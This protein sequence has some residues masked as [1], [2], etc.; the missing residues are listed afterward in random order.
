M[1]EY[2][3][4]QLSILGVCGEFSLLLSLSSCSFDLDLLQIVSAPTGTITKNQSI[5]LQTAT[6]GNSLSTQSPVKCTEVFN[7]HLSAAVGGNAKPNQTT[8]QPKKKAN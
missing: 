1:C 4:L 7:G 2:G 6:V 8:N 3:K 5:G